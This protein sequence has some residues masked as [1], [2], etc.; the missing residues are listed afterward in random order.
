M[1]PHNRGWYGKGWNYRGR[2]IQTE[3]WVK[4]LFPRSRVWVWGLLALFVLV[5]SAALAFTNN[6][7]NDA[8]AEAELRKL[9]DVIALVRAQYVDEVST[10]SL[11]SAYLEHGS[12]NDML[13]EVLDDPYTRYRRTQ[14]I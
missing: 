4:R 3:S 14:G 9:F 13:A 5:G 12:V 8:E 1:F 11:I 7:Y 6:F 10:M 2:A